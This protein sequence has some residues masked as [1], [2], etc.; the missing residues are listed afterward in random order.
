VSEPWSDRPA[1]ED[2][3][4][5]PG[6]DVDEPS[7]EVDEP[8]GEQVDDFDDPTTD[9]AEVAVG[10]APPDEAPLAERD[11]APA[12][13]DLVAGKGPV[14]TAVARLDSLADLPPAEHVEVYE[15]VHRVLQDALADAAHDSGGDGSGEDRTGS[16]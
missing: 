12:D 4:H 7:G 10:L 2:A 5:E 11:E 16:P 6:D 13:E 15:D 8:S 14:A 1:P 3:R 9:E